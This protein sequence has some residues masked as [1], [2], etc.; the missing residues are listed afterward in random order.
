ML[1]DRDR[2][3]SR[4]DFV[5][6]AVAIG[7]SSA[8]SA[9]LDREGS[10]LDGRDGPES[11]TA[12]ESED[13]LADRSVPS[14]DPDAV[15]ARQ[16]AWNEYIVHDAHDNTVIPQQQVLLGLTY[17][18]SVPPTEAEREQVESALQTLERAFQWGTGGD[19]TAS[20][21]RGLLFTLGYAPQYFERTGD[22]PDQL[23]PPEAVLEAVGEDPSNADDFDALL[24]L[25]SDIGSVVMAAEQ[26]LFGEAAVVNGV[27]VSESLEGVFSLA[28]RRTG[29]VGKG[30]PAEELDNESIPEDAP[31]SMG[32]KSGF[33]DSQ[34][35][36]DRVTIQEGPF[37]GG[38]TQA[39]SRLHI[40]LERW[41]DQPHEERAAEMFCPAHDTDE[42]GE[43][44]E[45]LGAESRITEENAENVEA[46]AEE[47]G[48]V[49]HTQKVA[50]ARDDEFVPT[51]LRR[52]EGIATDVSD[53]DGGTD[54]NFTSHQRHVDDFVETRKAMNTDEYDDDV[55]AENHGII[56]YLETR[57]RGTFLIPPR[58]ERALP[59]G[60]DA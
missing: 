50:A 24:L 1:P 34:P 25:T 22:V 57:H 3:L 56:D 49:G 59:T 44:G 38:T 8:L 17:E 47:Y 27:E 48:R 55:P 20:F 6:A 21:T 28:E 46:Y 51:I 16:H 18:G 60:V 31:L 11:P 45:R 52:S 23:R 13:A 10:L 58:D 35:S 32:F 26:A 30:N 9:C 33:R 2:G 37:A 36:E 43:I 15:P 53:L 12:T 19:P 40:D 14:G 29:I 41:Y 4:R 39:A 54:F 5:A 7:G 42:I